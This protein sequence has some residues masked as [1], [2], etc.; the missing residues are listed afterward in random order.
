MRVARQ[1][2]EARQDKN[3]ISRSIQL[4]GD[5][6]DD[7]EFQGEYNGDDEE[8]DLY[9]EEFDSDEIYYDSEEEA[10]EERKA[11][12]LAPQRQLYINK[13]AI[14]LGAGTATGSALAEDAN[15]EIKKVVSFTP[16][17]G[18]RFKEFDEHGFEKGSELS[19]LIKTDDSLPDYFIEAPAEMLKLATAKPKGH[20]KHVDKELKEMTEEGKL[21]RPA[22]YLPSQNTY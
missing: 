6:E 12:K 7:E 10:E 18:V 11:N 4:K 2:R 22:S 19:K 13:E 1:N 17:T 5:D 8:D 9:D 21:Q 16:A 14:D 20:F 3:Y 15:Q